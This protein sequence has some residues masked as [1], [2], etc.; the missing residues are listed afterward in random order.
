METIYVEMSPPMINRYTSTTR[1]L[2]LGGL[3]KTLGR[4][5]SL[6]VLLINRFKPRLVYSLA[7]L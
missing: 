4:D 1:T 6:S 7:V 3:L 5:D 2:T